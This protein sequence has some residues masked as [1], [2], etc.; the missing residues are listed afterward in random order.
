MRKP[1]YLHQ[2]LHVSLQQ[3]FSEGTGAIALGSNLGFK[4]GVRAKAG[5]VRVVVTYLNC[6]VER[7]RN[8]DDSSDVRGNLRV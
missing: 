5:G 3:V 4:G 8:K 7:L 1:W 6:V 2:N